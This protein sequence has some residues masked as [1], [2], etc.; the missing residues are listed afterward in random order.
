V[1]NAG[2]TVTKSIAISKEYSLPVF[3]SVIT[4][5]QAQSVFLVFGISL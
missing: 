1:I 5:P 2:C 3:G 4:N